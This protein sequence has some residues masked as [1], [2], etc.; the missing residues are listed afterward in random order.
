MKRLSAPTKITFFISLIIVIISIVA[1][2]VDIPVL[3][4]YQYWVMLV[5]WAFLAVGVIFKGL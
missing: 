1:H 4:Q 2:F 3:T 5:G